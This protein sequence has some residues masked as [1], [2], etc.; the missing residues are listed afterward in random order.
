[1][2]VRNAGTK[3]VVGARHDAAG[4]TIKLPPGRYT[5]EASKCDTA[6][7][8]SFGSQHGRSTQIDFVCSVK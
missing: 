5:I 6:G 8:I 3:E 1:V 4:F 7:P 2:T